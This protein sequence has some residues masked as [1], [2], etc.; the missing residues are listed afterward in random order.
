VNQGNEAFRAQ[1]FMLAEGLYSQAL[2]SV[3]PALSSD[4]K[5]VVHGNRANACYRLE[6]WE[7]AIDNYRR[8][9]MD[10]AIQW[11]AQCHIQLGNL[12]EG[13]FALQSALVL[14]P[15]RT[16][17]KKQLAQ[18]SA[19]LGRDALALALFEELLVDNPEDPRLLKSV[20]SRH[21]ALG[22]TDRALDTLEMSWRLG[23]REA[24]T[25]RLLADLYMGQ[26]MFLEAAGFYR[27]HLALSEDASAEDHFRI[28]YAYYQT[29]ERVSARGFFQLAVEL[30]AT[31]ADAFLYL[32]HLALAEGDEASALA[33]FHR[34]LAQ[35]PSIVAAHEAIGGIEM[36]RGNSEEAEA[37]YRS[38][39]ALSGAGF[40]SHYNLIQ[41][42]IQQGRRAD[43][44]S[45]LRKAFYQYPERG[46][47]RSI[48]DVIKQIP[49]DE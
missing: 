2:A 22:D 4:Q 39:L 25:A 24:N 27:K 36:R 19:M 43:A 14:F 45:A 44:L 17:L 16:D 20:A 21:L 34:S 23:G 15:K 47:L 35:D 13:A 41:I 28:G 12:P 29:G 32:G 8:S 48:V 37:A 33:E 40:A 30:D 7:D 6:R 10:D 5:L 38:A 1:D 9:S 42:C 3:D 31:Y 49:K 18:V 11:I 26:G 46:E